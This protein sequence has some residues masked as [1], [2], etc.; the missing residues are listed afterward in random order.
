MLLRRV[1]QLL[2]VALS[3][4]RYHPFVAFRLEMDWEVKIDEVRVLL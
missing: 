1:P 2:L 4:P 3:I